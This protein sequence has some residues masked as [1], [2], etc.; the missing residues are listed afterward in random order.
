MAWHHKE[1]KFDDFPYSQQLPR[2]A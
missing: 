2:A 1:T